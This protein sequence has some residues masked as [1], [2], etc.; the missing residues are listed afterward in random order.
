LTSARK[1]VSLWFYEVLDAEAVDFVSPRRHCS[2]YGA[3]LRSA[4]RLLRRQFGLPRYR[5][6]P[7]GVDFRKHISAALEK[8][9]VLLAIIGE[10]WLSIG[11]D[12]HSRLENEKDHVRIEIESALQRPIPIIPVL[13]GN[14]AMPDVQ[15]LPASL[16]DFSYY[17]GVRVDPE[18]DFN[19]HIGRLTH[20]IDK[21]TGYRPPHPGRRKLVL[22]M[23]AAAAVVLFAAGTWA[24]LSW[25]SRPAWTSVPYLA[26]AYGEIG[27]QE[28]LGR[29]NNPRILQYISSVA[30]TEGVQD[31]EIDWA[32]PFVEWCLNQVGIGG[33]KSLDPKAWKQWGRESETPQV[34]A[35]AVFKTGVD[36]WHVSFVV[37]VHKDTLEILGGNQSD[38][39]RISVYRT[40]TAEAF[41]LP[42]A[43]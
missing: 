39:V 1:T 14:A 10:R 43:Q 35:I 2:D 23:A 22:S 15:Q 30:S 38:Q 42:P 19:H 37:A 36:L 5:N 34:G 6:I 29:E 26:V 31:D 3:D 25:W 21:L 16:Q 9:D 32:S 27:Q 4:Q 28:I 11:Q 7:A 18:K 8:S 40:S 17:N 41:R 33:P 12:G 24:Y 13:I 20:E